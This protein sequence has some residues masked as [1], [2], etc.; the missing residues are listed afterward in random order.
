MSPEN[1]GG[2]CPDRVQR[3]RLLRRD[4]GESAEAG[5]GEVLRR[6]P[7]FSVFADRTGATCGMRH[8]AKKGAC[9]HADQNRDAGDQRHETSGFNRGQSQSGTR[10]R[11]G[12]D[13][14]VLLTGRYRPADSVGAHIPGWH[15]IAHRPQSAVRFPRIAVQA[16]PSPILTPQIVPVHPR[17][18]QTDHLRIHVEL[19][20]KYTRHHSRIPI[21]A[22][23]LEL[24]ALAAYHRSKCSSSPAPT[25]LVV[26]P[27]IKASEPNTNPPARELHEE[28]IAIHDASDCA[29]QNRA[30]SAH[31]EQAGE[32]HGGRSNELHSTYTRHSQHR[33]TYSA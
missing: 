20:A 12:Q 32:Q 5:T 14:A 21:L 2:E 3:R 13:P 29:K 33:P 10:S 18:T 30:A 4:V 23:R 16:A 1:A 22:D 6:H 25:R 24:H 31:T 26:L 7:P 8:A 9:T 17:I 11:R 19:P 27:G 28:R 15:G